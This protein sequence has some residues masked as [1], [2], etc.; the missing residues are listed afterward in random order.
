MPSLKALFGSGDAFG[1]VAAANSCGCRA[2]EYANASVAGG[3][4]S[5]A[6]VC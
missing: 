4:R 3:V 1:D 2:V 5:D 6:L